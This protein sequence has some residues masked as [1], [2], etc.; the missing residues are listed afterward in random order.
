M[1]ALASCFG[2]C[3]AGLPAFSRSSS[4]SEGALSRVGI[5]EVSAVSGAGAGSSSLPQQQHPQHRAAASASRGGRDADS[6]GRE[7]VQAGGLSIDWNLGFDGAGPVAPVTLLA[8]FLGAG[9]TTLLKRLLENRS[10][11]RVGV[12]VNDV[13]AVNV[14]AQLV[15]SH[16]AGADGVEVAQLQNGCVCCSLADDLFTSI[17][18]LMAKSPDE[19]FD[20]LIVELSGVSEPSAVRDNWIV[21]R[22]VNHPAALR[23]EIRRVVTVVDASCF[24]ND[25]LDGRD[26]SGRNAPAGDAASAAAAPSTRPVVDLL[27]EQIETA[28]VVLINKADLVSEDQLRTVEALVNGIN[29]RA[30]VVKGEF[31]GVD[32]A[33]LLPPPTDRRSSAAPSAREAHG[34]HS[35]LGHNANGDCQDH[36]CSHSHG[37]GNGHGHGHSHGGG[38]V[39]VSPAQ[40][41]GISS[42][43]YRARRPFDSARFQAFVD[44]LQAK[45]LS[46]PLGALHGPP[47]SALSGLM[48]AKGTCWLT[49]APLHEHSWS[50][51]GLTATLKQGNPWWAACSE[52]HI[53]LRAA[54]PGMQGIYDQVR[55]EAWDQEGGCGDRRQELVFIGGPGM[56]EEVLRAE[57]DDC[58]LTEAE[59][60]VFT[61]ANHDAVAPFELSIGGVSMRM[62]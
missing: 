53:F 40:R 18:A 39:D 34:N 42:F 27:A 51:A 30:Q 11:L 1:R 43:V 37:H 44:G 60:E 49:S 24:A 58:L 55:A 29:A 20:H 62:G 6:G 13:A 59:M 57:I 17:S 54:Y 35:Q 61:E 21:A 31:G 56:V 50:F 2:S 41:Y 32:P 16:L 23:S 33:S 14:D 5:R 38:R 8:G 45:R 36:N 15:T 12:I 46:V 48:R 28:D 47:E 3:G 7:A 22:E 26:A 10:G 52:Q 25:W 19:G 9:K 4:S